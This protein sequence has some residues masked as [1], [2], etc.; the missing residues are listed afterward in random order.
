VLAGLCVAFSPAISAAANILWTESLFAA[1]TVAALLVYVRCGDRLRGLIVVGVLVGVSTMVRPTGLLLLL[2]L[3]GWLLLWGWCSSNQSLQ[4]RF[5]LVGCIALVSGYLVVAAPWHLHLAFVR[6]TTDLSNGHANFTAWAA[7]IYQRRI[8]PNLV[9]NRPDRAIWAVPQT[10]SYDPFVLLDRY[11]QLR[12]GTPSNFQDYYTEAR[13]EA[14]Q[15]DPARLRE[16][17]RSSLV[18]NLTFAWTGGGDYSYWPELSAILDTWKSPA[19]A[20]TALAQDNPLYQL[21]QMAY[22]WQPAKSPIRSACVAMSLFVLKHWMWLAIPALLSLALLLVSARLHMFV[23]L[24]LY[25]MGIV[26]SSTAIGMPA[27]R[28]VMVTEPLLYVLLS[29]SIATIVSLRYQRTRARH[30]ETAMTSVRAEGTKV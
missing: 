18:Y 29:C 2:A 22:R 27:E 11:P 23:P 25:W 1:F 28:Y 20:P 12:K 10:W 9:A 4:Q 24:W 17:L 3:I 16:N 13:R 14:A 21:A 6:G 7:A 26:L 5:A 15:A 8:T 19:Q 30:T